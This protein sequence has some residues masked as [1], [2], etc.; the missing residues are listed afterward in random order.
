MSIKKSK[1]KYLT[2]GCFN[3]TKGKGLIPLIVQEKESKKVLMLGYVNKQALER[4]LKFKKV[5]FW[6]RTRKTLWL[7]GKKSKH[8]LLIQE[9]FLDCDND[10]LL[11]LVKE[12]ND[13]TPICHTGK[14]SCFFKKII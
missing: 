14:N 11:A 12:S 4:C 13:K 9:L 10:A 8:F 6:S 2:T 1:S 3:F 5:Y 7:K